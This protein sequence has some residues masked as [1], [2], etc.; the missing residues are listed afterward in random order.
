MAR[1]VWTPPVRVSTP[2][3]WVPFS[4]ISCPHLGQVK[5]AKSSDD[6]WMVLAVPFNRSSKACAG[7]R[8]GWICK[9]LASRQ[10]DEFTACLEAL[11]EEH[12]SKASHSRT[13]LPDGILCF[14][15]AALLMLAR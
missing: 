5:T 13:Q 15:G 4:R 3:A 14:P 8:F 9:A 11:L 7:M 2:L 12:R 1:L 10:P 6:R